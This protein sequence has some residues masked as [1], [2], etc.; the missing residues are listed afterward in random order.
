MV[1]RKDNLSVG[2]PWSHCVHYMW[3]T[4][5]KP[6]WRK[7]KSDESVWIQRVYELNSELWFCQSIGAWTCTVS[8]KRKSYR[9]NTVLIW[10][11]N[12]DSMCWF[13]QVSNAFLRMYEY[14]VL[15][16]D[17]CWLQA[18]VEHVN[19]PAVKSC[20]ILRQHFDISDLL[21]GHDSRWI[22]FIVWSGSEP[23]RADQ[24]P[25]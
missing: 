14:S 18:L 16:L 22:D 4:T 19:R 24:T 9:E 13:S 12:R 25:I 7:R 10:S 17:W 21:K 20:W 8:K 11:K 2:P 6:Q 1:I 15:R 3:D 23:S 5:A